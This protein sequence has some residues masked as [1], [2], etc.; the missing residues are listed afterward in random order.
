MTPGP[1]RAVAPAMWPAPRAIALVLG[2]AAVLACGSLVHALIWVAAVLGAALGGAI[3]ADAAAG[4]GVRT[5]RAGREPLP[6][7]ALG[8]EALAT[9]VLE[10]RS[11]LGARVALFETPV[12]TI[13]FPAMGCRARVAPGERAV[14]TAVFVPQERGT[15]VFGDVYGW[16]ES[17]LGLVR[18]R[19]RI[20]AA[21]TARV[22]PDLSGG[23]GEALSSRRT[24]L[25]LGLRRL[26]AR[27][28]GTDFA[29]LREYTDGDAFGAIDWKATAR[30]GTLTV[31]EREVERGQRIVLVLDCGRL[32]T[33]RVGVRRK[34]DR[35]LE[36]ALA[37]ARLAAEA[38]DAVGFEAFAARPL[39]TLAP[40]RGRAALEAI[41]R[42]SVDLRARFEEP[43]YETLAADVRRRHG[44][45][46]LVV[47]FTDVVDPVASAALLAGIATIAVRHLVLCVVTNDA[48]VD[49]E[50][51][52]VP[53]TPAA[54]YRTAIAMTLAT[55]RERALAELR[56][57]GVGVV[58]VAAG[59]LTV[60]VLDAYL[61]IKERGA[62]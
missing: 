12:A 30:R 56:A 5:L 54:A 15:F 25:G 27:G 62:L 46:S 55:E 50:L 58:D 39:L 1:P 57:R 41:V 35:A 8:R 44:R 17:S 49:R 24:R 22:Y 33:P 16:V 37:L 19:F 13:R 20:G 28:V 61:A 40:R 59:A 60:G 11:P 23:A 32:M 36:T 45:R 6:R 52:A 29:S 4:P 34:L 47:L 7:L 21:E 31:V 18:R 48:A 3:L 2:I 10:N 53:T 43:D 42:A 9:Y 51:A 26:R 38:G 14:A